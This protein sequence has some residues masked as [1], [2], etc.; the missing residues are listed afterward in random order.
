MRPDRAA[1]ARPLLV[2][3]HRGVAGRG[4]TFHENSLAAFQAAMGS[5]DGVETDACSDADGEVFLLHESRYVS[6]EAGV[7]YCLGDHL[8]A[9]SRALVGRRRID[10]LPTALMRSLRLRDGSAIPTLRRLL[11]LAARYPQSV[12]DIELKGPGCA[13]V[14]LARLHEAMRQGVVRPQQLLLSSFD[15]P[16]LLAVREV[17]PALPVGAIFLTSAQ[18]DTPMY[19]WRPGASGRYTALRPQALADPVLQQVQPNYVVMPQEMLSEAVVE[20]VDR[21]FPRAALMAWTFTEA[22][23]LDLQDLLRRLLQLQPTG[24]LAAMIVDQPDL[25]LRQAQAAGIQLGRPQASP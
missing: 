11:A 23:T 7:E 17:A 3:G 21:R 10:Q 2:L 1:A 6:S 19:P 13:G 18:R 12:L 8:D 15:H 5:C 9:P 22:P 25:F 24:K 4:A 14:V 20:W 16:A